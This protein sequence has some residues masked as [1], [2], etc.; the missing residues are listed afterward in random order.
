MLAAA[1]SAGI[2]LSSGDYR[3][4]GSQVLR[5]PERGPGYTGH[6]ND[7]DSG[8]AYM[9]ARYYDPQVGRMLS[10]DPHGITAANIRTFNRFAYANGRPIKNVGPD[11]R[12]VV[13]AGGSSDMRAFRAWPVA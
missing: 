10:P 11:G 4:Y 6:V 12:V 5:T 9:Q 1:D 7:V 8:L 13:V 2:V 3:P